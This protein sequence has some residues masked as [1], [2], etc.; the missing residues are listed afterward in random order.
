MNNKKMLFFDIDGTL[1]PEG[2]ECVPESTKKAI[3]QARANGHLLFIN[4]GRTY[5]N[6]DPII[7]ELNFHGYVCGCGT[8]IYYEGQKLF[9]RTI[10]H[11]Q[12][13]N[14]IRLMR[15]CRIPGFYEENEHIYFDTDASA[16][17]AHMLESARRIFGTKAYDFP[18]NIFDPSFTFDKILAYIQPDSD[19]STFQEYSKH[20][21]EYIDR[22]GNIAEIIQ[23]GYSKAT[24]I[25]FLCDHLGIPINNCYAIG[26]STNDLSMLEYVPNSIAMGNSDTLVKERCLYITDNVEHDGIYNAMKH[27]GLI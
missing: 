9:G 21:L 19:I 12:C 17:S 25:Q 23:K 6:I 8:Y 20:I 10:P 1:I 14:L 3:S 11:E 24:G 4:T 18:E 7:R 2:G 5:F 15:Q 26:D 16:P 27:F 13:L 22:G